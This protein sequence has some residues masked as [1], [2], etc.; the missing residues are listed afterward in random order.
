MKTA[1]P[2]PTRADEAG[3]GG[4]RGHG[5]AAEADGLDDGRVAH[6]GVGVGCAV[7]R[8][9]E[10]DRHLDGRGEPGVAGAGH[11]DAEV[12]AV[13]AHGGD[14]GGTVDAAR[15]IGRCLAHRHGDVEEELVVP[16]MK[17]RQRASSLAVARRSR[18]RRRELAQQQ[19]RAGDVP[20]MHLV[21]HAEAA[22][23]EWL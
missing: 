9:I 2:K 20:L 23:D 15:G 14:D 13:A 3:D 22:G 8:E 6:V 21:A 12:G 10:P 18:Q 19:A 16:P 17:S 4:R 1:A 5:K 11:A 7:A